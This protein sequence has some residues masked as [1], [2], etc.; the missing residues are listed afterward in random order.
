MTMLL[1][2]SRSFSPELF[3]CSLSLA[4]PEYLMRHIKRSQLLNEC[5]FNDGTC[6]REHRLLGAR[7]DHNPL[8][9]V[10]KMSLVI[11]IVGPRLMP[12]EQHHWNGF[13]FAVYIRQYKTLFYD[14]NVA[15][16]NCKLKVCDFRWQHEPD[17]CTIE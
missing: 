17:L 3:F 4:L 11:L 15:I 16:N 14:V 9:V 10:L 2:K 13:F 1:Y 8:T 6:E 7:I 12:S 5:I